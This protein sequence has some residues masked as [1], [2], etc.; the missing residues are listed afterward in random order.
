MPSITYLT[1]A[2][3]LTSAVVATPV[4][5]RDV[6][7]VEQ[8]KHSV[9]LKNGPAQVAKTLRKYGKVVPEHIQAAA[10]ARANVCL[11]MGLAQL[12]YTFLHVPRRSLPLP[13][14]L[15]LSL[16][17]PTMST[18]RPTSARSPLVPPP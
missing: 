10:D 18:T 16:P 1:A 11:H 13:L 12:E 15:V 2:L 6:F 4:Q 9:H 3:A 5:K 7:S 8:V 17:T 14:A